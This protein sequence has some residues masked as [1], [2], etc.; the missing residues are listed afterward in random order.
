MTP[1]QAFNIARQTLDDDYLK[2]KNDKLDNFR[3]IAIFLAKDILVDLEEI[4]RQ[5][6]VRGHF[7]RKGIMK[8]IEQWTVPQIR[9]MYRKLGFYI[10]GKW[11]DKA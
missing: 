3:H 7:I 9:E 6:G 4:E 1:D 11:I 2:D 5:S 10:N 8:Q